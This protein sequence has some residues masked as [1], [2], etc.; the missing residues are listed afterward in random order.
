MLSNRD[1]VPRLAVRSDVSP[2]GTAG[3]A[4]RITPS[5]LPKAKR[6]EAERQKQLLCDCKL[7]PSAAPPG[8]A[9]SE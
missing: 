9:P 8:L 7:N 1:F 5:S 4:E 3:K 6:S 2:A